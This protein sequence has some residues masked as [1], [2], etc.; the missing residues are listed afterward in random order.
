[1]K[2]LLLLLGMSLCLMNVYS[3][4]PVPRVA[5][6][7]Q[8]D[9]HLFYAPLGLYGP[10]GTRLE[11]ERMHSGLNLWKAILGKEELMYGNSNLPG[12]GF[13]M[14]IPM[15][16]VAFKAS[17]AYERSAFKMT[18]PGE[19]ESRVHIANGVKPEFDLYYVM[20]SPTDFLKPAVFLGGAYH[21]PLSFTKG[22]S[23][24]DVAMLNKGFEVIGGFSALFIPGFADTYVEHRGNYTLQVTSSH[25]NLYIEVALLYRYT[26]YNYFNQDYTQGTVMPYSGITSKYGEVCFRLTGGGFFPTRYQR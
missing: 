15:V 8:G 21:C 13:F 24:A 12:L 19:T 17:C 18:Y 6:F 23:E 2:K 5:M 9:L 26:L 16:P 22:K 4:K 14:T 1:M 20:G 3:Q 7:Y 11:M 10:D 25:K